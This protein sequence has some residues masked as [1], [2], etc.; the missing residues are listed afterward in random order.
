LSPEV[1]CCRQQYLKKNPN[2]FCPDHGTGVSCPVVSVI[3]GTGVKADPA[4]S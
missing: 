2:G 1:K 4:E 3:A